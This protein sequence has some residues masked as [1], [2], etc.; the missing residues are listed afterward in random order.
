MASATA[1]TLLSSAARTAS[2]SGS[3]VDVSG[4]A[5][6]D[7]YLE[8][9]A[10]AGTSPTLSVQ[11]ETSRD[12]SAWSA[13][14]PAVAVTAV[15]TVRIV[16]AGAQR[17]VRVSYTVSGS[18]PSF[19]FAIGGDSL[20]CYAVPADVGNIEV[21][22]AADDDERA[23][24]TAE[25]FIERSTYADGYLRASGK[26]TLPL[27]A[28]GRDLRGAVAKLATWDVLSDVVGMNPE[29]AANSNW[30]ARRDEALEWLRGVA[31]GSIVVEDVADTTPT[32][33]ESSSVVYT[34][35]RRGWGSW[36]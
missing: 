34:T 4:K 30:I 5:G 22:Q 28:W 27:T 32:V 25:K 23:N 13:L 1:V 26:L 36:P 18:S 2:G 16:R 35:A 24:G 19:T 9:T 31:R 7:V 15:G 11:V 14:G 6:L 12:G 17:Y 3:S 33:E 21:R 8:V 10:V 20:V 29:D